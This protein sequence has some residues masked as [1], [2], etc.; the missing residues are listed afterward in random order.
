MRRIHDVP[1]ADV[2]PDVVQPVEEHEVSGLEL[3]PRH[4]DSHRVVPLRD[5]VVRQRDPELGEHVL[6]EPGAVEAAGRRSAPHVRDA[7]VLQREGDHAVVGADGN[8]ERPARER[9]AAR[10]VSELAEPPVGE[11][12]RFWSRLTRASAAS[13][14]T[15]PGRRACAPRAGWRAALRC[16]RRGG[17]AAR[18]VRAS[19]HGPVRRRAACWRRNLL[20]RRYELGPEVDREHSGMTPPPRPYSAARPS[21]SFT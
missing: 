7:E 20:T 17:S 18:C 13:R 6:D 12:R 15:P 4:G 9:G 19:R 1:V 10:L 5:G 2:D 8:A 14:R 21:T 16:R 11:S 3:V